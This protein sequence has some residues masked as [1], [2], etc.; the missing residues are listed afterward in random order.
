MKKIKI[1]IFAF[2]VLVS[3][4]TFAETSQVKSLTSST[5]KA[6]KN[7]NA[8]F[9]QKV[10]DWGNR[11]ET[12]RD[13]E[14]NP[15]LFPWRT[16]GKIHPTGEGV[17]HG[18]AFLVGPCTLQTSAHLVFSRKGQ[19]I[20]YLSVT[21][22][23]PD[24]PAN[25]LGMW[26]TI[27]V[28]LETD[29]LD[30]FLTDEDDWNDDE[31]KPVGDKDAVILRMKHCSESN[32]HAIGTQL[33]FFGRFNRND[34]GRSVCTPDNKGKIEAALRRQ[35]GEGAKDNYCSKTHNTLDYFQLA[36]D[37]AGED[38][39]VEDRDYVVDAPDTRLCI[40]GFNGDK[41]GKFFAGRSCGTTGLLTKDT[42][43][44]DCDEGLIGQTSGSPLFYED[45]LCGYVGLAVNSAHTTHEVAENITEP[46]ERAKAEVAHCLKGGRYEFEEG[47]GCYNTATYVDVVEPPQP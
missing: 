5:I 32:P 16:I 7:L 33:G 23:V 28:D 4:Q 18:T 6:E 26:T 29:F 22:K 21:F 34:Q 25:P 35:V 10:L 42:P 44:H 11:G 15:K 45:Q 30:H 41:G 12:A 14:V 27:T 24:N 31:T 43:T 46:V 39:D 47:N 1:A 9:L 37:I 2:T 19:P 38:E 20:K 17:D 3:T 40:G 8:Q 36:E 13:G